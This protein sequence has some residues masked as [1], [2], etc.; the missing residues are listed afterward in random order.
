MSLRPKLNLSILSDVNRLFD[1]L[2][3]IKHSSWNICE[4]STR[5]GLF[6]DS[7]AESWIQ[8]KESLYSIE[9]LEISPCV[10][11]IVELHVFPDASSLVFGITV[12]IKCSDSSHNYFQFVFY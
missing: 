5:Q 10:L 9:K 4:N 2:V 12:Y 1:P 8:F 3:L 11:H 7:V 6:H